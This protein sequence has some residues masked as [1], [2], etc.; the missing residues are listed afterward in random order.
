MFL[1][2]LAYCNTPEFGISRITFSPNRCNSTLFVYDT[3]RLVSGAK[4]SP[5]IFLPSLVPEK[6]LENVY[7]APTKCT[8]IFK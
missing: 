5:V 1:P 2:I 8:F 7:Q 3:V 6:E 4:E